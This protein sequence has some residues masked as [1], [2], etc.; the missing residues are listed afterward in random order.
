[1]AQVVEVT[2]INKWIPMLGQMVLGLIL[3][4]ALALV[5]IPLE[6][7]GHSGRIVFGELLVISFQGSAMVLRSVGIGFR[8]AGQWLTHVYDVFIFLP[9]WIERMVKKQPGSGMMKNK[10][11]KNG[12]RMS[13]VGMT[14]TKLEVGEAAK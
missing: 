6:S 8:H 3:P 5:A 9:L 12:K 4:F 10:S 13:Q 7:L 11:S 14:E 2:G 1:V